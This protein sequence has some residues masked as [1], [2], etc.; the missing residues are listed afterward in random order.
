MYDISK[1]LEFL[2]WL[3]KKNDHLRHKWIKDKLIKNLFY[4]IA[5]NLTKDIIL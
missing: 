4:L 1:I 3:A 5:S 2:G